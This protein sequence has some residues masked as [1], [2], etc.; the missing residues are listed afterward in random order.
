M[1]RHTHPII[2]EDFDDDTDL[3]LPSK[4]LPNFGTRGALIQAIDSESDDDGP[5]DDDME[6]PVKGSL[7][8]GPASPSQ[9]SGSLAGR[10]DPRNTVSDLTPYKKCVN[11]FCSSPILYGEN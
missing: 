1:A 10:E 8:P 2:E 4:P 6:V 5:L 3:P 9:L 11:C 7:N